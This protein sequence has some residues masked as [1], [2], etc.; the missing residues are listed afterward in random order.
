MKEDI[1]ICYLCGEPLVGDIHR[2]HVPP[3]QFYAREVRTKHSPNLFTLPVHSSCNKAY[4]KDEDYFMH[5]IAPLAME[6]YSGKALWHDISKQYGRPQGRRIGKMILEEFQERPSGLIL[7]SG[8]VAK[9]FDGQRVWRVVWKITR[10]LFFKEM[11]RF[12]PDETPRTYKIF[13]A[14][15]NPPPEFDF[16]RNLLPQGQYP[17]VFDYKYIEFTEKNF[18]FWAML[19]WDKIIIFV[20]F[21]DPHCKCKICIDKSSELKL[22]YY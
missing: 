18:H 1:N 15:E 21:H 11:G 4:Q 19:F 8:K 16:V 2:D 13:S 7:P 3:R 6:S 5:S 10:G 14:G 12:L 9:K 22:C 20:G 17:G